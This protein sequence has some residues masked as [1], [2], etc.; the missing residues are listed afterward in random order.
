MSLDIL[1]TGEIESYERNRVH[2]RFKDMT[3]SNN[4]LGVLNVE[5][6]WLGRPKIVQTLLSTTVEKYVDDIGRWYEMGNRAH[7]KKLSGA[8]MPSELE[9]KYPDRDYIPTEQYISN[10]INAPREAKNKRTALHSTQTQI[11][12]PTSGHFSNTDAV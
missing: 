5:S 1:K 6:G 12:R 3:V 7:G 11:E 8:Y 9:L 2:P 4:V 10:E